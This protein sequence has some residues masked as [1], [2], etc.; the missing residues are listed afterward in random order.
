[1]I[2]QRSVHRLL[3]DLKYSMKSNRKRDEGSQNHPDRDAQFKYINDQAIA[4]QAKACPVL[5]VDAKK[6]ENIGLYKNNGREWSPKGEPEDVKVYDFIDKKKGKAAPYGVLDVTENEG[7]VSIGISSDT[8]EFAVA[9]LRN[10]WQEMGKEKY[11]NSPEIMITAD[12]GG[13]NANRTRLWKYELQRLANELNKTITVYHFPPGT[14][15]WNKIEHRLF[16]YISQNWRARPLIDLQTIVELIG[17]TK[18]TTGLIVKTKVDTNG[19]QKGRKVSK[20]Q[21]NAINI[22][23]HE[24]HPEWNYSISPNNA[25]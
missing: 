8:A 23:P 16:S 19:Y 20:D 15:K 5:S 13:S 10:W 6:K 22:N 7:W 24:F 18:T 2:T 3:T 9:S 21:F 12:C 25:K 11:R 14:S 17:N 1:M 4:S